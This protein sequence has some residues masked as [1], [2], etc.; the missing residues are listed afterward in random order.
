MGNIIYNK[1]DEEDLYTFTI[2]AEEVKKTRRILPF[3][4]DADKFRIIV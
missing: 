3:L 2:N 1:R 4:K